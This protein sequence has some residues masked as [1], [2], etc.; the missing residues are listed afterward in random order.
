MNT[1][2]LPVMPKAIYD[3]PNDVYIPVNIGQVKDLLG[4]VLTQIEAMNLSEKAE[5]ANKSI[6]KQ[7][8]WLW[9]ENAQENSL[10]SW[11][12]CIG[13]IDME[14]RKKT[15]GWYDAQKDTFDDSKPDTKVE[16]PE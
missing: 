7:T 1:A 9:W 2:Q 4:K 13:P 11:E 15:L 12:R 8:I 6:A 5:N 3:R 14:E 10:T 16:L